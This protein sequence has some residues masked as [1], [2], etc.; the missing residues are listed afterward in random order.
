LESAFL[1]HFGAAIT[2]ISLHFL[3][4]CAQ[5]ISNIFSGLSFRVLIN[6]STNR[7]TMKKYALLAAVCAPFWLYAQVPDSWTQKTSLPAAPRLGAVAFVIGDKAY[8]GTGRDDSWNLLKDFWQYDAVTD[9]WTRIADFP[10]T[11]RSHAVAFSINDKGYVGT[12]YDGQRVN[13]FWRYDPTAGTWSQIAALGNGA[14]AG[15]YAAATFVLNNHGYVISGY[16]GTARNSYDTWMYDDVTSA[17]YRKADFTHMEPN[18]LTPELYD[19]I[20][21]YLSRRWSSGF[22]KDD[23]GYICAGYTYGHEYMNDLWRYSASMDKWFHADSLH[24]PSREGASCFVLGDYAYVGTG[25]NGVYLDDFYSYSIGADQW[26]PVAKFE[27]QKMCEGVGFTING[28]GYVCAGRIGSANTNELWEYT[29][30]TLAGVQQLA[31]AND[32]S[33]YPN[34]AH[35]AFTVSFGETWK[36]K[37]MQL[38]I[39]DEMGSLVQEEK[40][41]NHFDSYRDDISNSLSPGIYLVQISSGEKTFAQRLVIE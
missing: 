36:M 12:G 4:S 35:D 14:G 8:V 7:N 22:G 29:P 6:V 5:K 3:H 34:P 28:K 15:R 38:K 10:G 11:A 30:D 23:N 2:K 18:L 24:A 31:S 33:I 27:G 20:L 21:V 32:F 26:K 19:S 25:Y 16:D 37:S 1:K 41:R 9:S 17:W 39:Y 40:I 13:D